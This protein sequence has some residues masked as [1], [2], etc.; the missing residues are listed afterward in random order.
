MFHFSVGRNDK[1][2]SRNTH[3]N[4]DGLS[5]HHAEMGSST[6]THPSSSGRCEFPVGCYYL[7]LKKYFETCLHFVLKPELLSIPRGIC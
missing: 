3:E 1:L 5:G 2:Y 4:F 7:D 6:H